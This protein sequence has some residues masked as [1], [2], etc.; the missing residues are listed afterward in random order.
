M[1]GQVASN[2]KKP[3]DA[4]AVVAP[5]HSV[6]EHL[7]LIWAY[8]ELWW[9]LSRKELKVKYKNSVLG[10]AWS[11][12]N[13]A[14]YLVIYY[15]VFQV[16]LG[17]GIENFPIFLLSG[18]LVWTMY[19]A[20]LTAG[21][22]SIV[23]NPS[24]VK[25]VYFPREVLPLATMGAAFLHFLLQFS[26][27]IA[28]LVAF[29]WSVSLEFV[30]LV[31]PALLVTVLLGSALGILLSAVN[32]YARDTQHLLELLVLLW[33]WL[34]PIVYPYMLIVEKLPE[35]WSWVARLNPMTSVVIA[36]QRAIYDRPF[37]SEG[38]NGTAILPPDATAW[39]YFRN[40]LIIALVAVVLLWFAIRVFDR[41]EGNFA[42]EI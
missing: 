42:E 2:A 9:E 10:F 32:V 29:R 34:T 26:V 19:S 24:L 12:L 21:A 1:A 40:L 39:W 36:F 15:I 5:R 23:S 25:K 14:M 41:T 11:L 4:I 33:F 16:L 18:L 37:G 38:T 3:A 30:W 20:S 8:R 27:L 17:S 31:L 6:S 28:A 7:G 22:G 13:P 35:G